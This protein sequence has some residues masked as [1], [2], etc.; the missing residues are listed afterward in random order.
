M[1]LFLKNVDFDIL[2]KALPIWLCKLT[3]LHRVFPLKQGMFD[4]LIVDE[5][6]QCDMASILPALQRA[7]KVV[8]C[9]DPNQ[10][11]HV[12]FLS[13]SKMRVLARKFKLTPEQQTR[14]DFRS[15][16]ILDLVSSSLA[17]QEQLSFLNEHFRSDA[18][19]IGFSNSEFYSNDLRIMTEKPISNPD[20]GTFTVKCEGVRDLRGVNELEAQAIVKAVKEV[21]DKEKDLDIK[22]KTS[23]GILSPF[24]DQTNFLSKLI[25]EQL[26]VNEIVN[27]EIAIGTSYSFQGEERDSMFL[28]FVV[29]KNTHHSSFIHLN[30]SDVFNVAITRAKNKQFVYHS[31]DPKDVPQNNYLR[32]YLERVSDRSSNTKIEDN[33][34]S[35]NKF[36]NE[37]IEYLKVPNLK[38]WIYYSI[39]GIPIDILI[40]TQGR[41]YGIDLIGYPGIYEDAL[42]VERYKILGRTGIPIFPLPYTFWK[43]DRESCIVQLRKFLNLPD[44]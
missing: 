27:H 13:R 38:T 35:H 40:F 6:S 12:S 9:G 4:L 24:R 3:D 39:A 21:I 43:F 11:R 15:T 29:D 23:I 42:S 2:L 34:I 18:H 26:E 31:L 30:K 41:Y 14:F 19:I 32:S 5:A 28:S 22:L 33:D 16:S 44:S 25:K 17:S 1:I 36:L 10:L 8:F 37:V 7:K 20:L